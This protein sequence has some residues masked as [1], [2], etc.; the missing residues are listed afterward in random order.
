MKFLT[1]TLYGLALDFVHAVH[2]F[3]IRSPLKEGLLI[4]QHHVF[5]FLFTILK[6]FGALV[7]LVVVVVA[8]GGAAVPHLC[9]YCGLRL[10]FCSGLCGARRMRIATRLP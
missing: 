8:P 4:S 9:V 6:F 10:F 5:L 3:L 2:L 7:I 1:Y